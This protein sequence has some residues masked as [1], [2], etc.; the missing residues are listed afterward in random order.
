MVKLNIVSW[1][2]FHIAHVL[3]L[4]QSQP[5][6]S[7]LSGTLCSAPLSLSPLLPLWSRPLPPPPGLDQWALNWS[8][9]L[10]SLPHMGVCSPRPL[11]PSF[12]HSRPPV[13]PSGSSSNT[14]HFPPISFGY[15][16]GFFHSAGH[17]L[18]LCM[19]L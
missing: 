9:L 17:G 4:L 1:P 7:S 6:F 2:S 5:P 12:P 11:G 13:H 3:P 15:P 16:L 10:P 14:P 8:P 19:K 18:C